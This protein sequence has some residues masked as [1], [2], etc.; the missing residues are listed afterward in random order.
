VPPPFTTRRRAPL[1]IL[2]GAARHRDHRPFVGPISTTQKYGC[3]PAYGDPPHS[4]SPSANRESWIK[5]QVDFPSVWNAERGVR[6]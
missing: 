4:S 2:A 5:P 1:I 6:I 3:A